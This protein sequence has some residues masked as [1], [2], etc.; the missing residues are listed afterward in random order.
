MDIIGQKI[1]LKF[2]QE[3]DSIQ[4]TLSDKSINSEFNYKAYT[5]KTIHLNIKGQ[6][7]K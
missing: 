6:I 7:S 3:I 2:F 5:R 4:T 1:G